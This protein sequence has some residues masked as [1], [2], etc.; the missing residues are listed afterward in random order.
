MR[1]PAGRATLLDDHPEVRPGGALV[2]SYWNLNRVAFGGGR[3]IEALLDLLGS[4]AVLVQPAPAHPTRCC[5][6]FRPDL[7]RRKLGVNWGLFNFFLPPAAATVR[8][9][10][11]EVQPAV[12]VLTSVWAW[13]PLRGLG[14]R[15]PTVLDAHDVLAAAIAERF[16]PRHPFTRLVG[17]WE[18]A[19]VRAVDHLIV[20]SD[21]DAAGMC[22]RYGVAK[23]RVSVVPNGT[24][25]DLDQRA[26]EAP[27]DAHVLRRLADAG[28]VLLFMGKLDY[29]PNREAL[30]FLAD[31]VLPALDAAAP[32]RWRLLV[33]GGPVPSGRWPAAVVFTGR[34]PEVAPYL[35][36]ADVCVAP[37]FSGS[38]T[39][40][41]I[42][43]AMAAGRPVVA[44]PKAAEGLTAENGRHLL[45]AEATDFAAAV[46]RL[47]E[48]AE[49]AA[50][51]GQSGRELVRAQY[52]WDA[53]RARWRSVLQRWMELPPDRMPLPR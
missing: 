22:A 26:R 3:R 51:I 17:A 27:L 9:T 6:V 10:I 23:D 49:L 42:L 16:G 34:V 29:Q 4:R 36:R 24:D 2:L 1:L 19:V 11:R 38:G 28:R 25:L 40:L 52:S 33:V 41:K 35:V 20:C 7:G 37:I 18:G 13:A 21:A 47:G 12:V 31:V 15:P 8:R 48:D 44:T 5:R 46:L 14:H 39:R 53:S 32:G 30:R 43:E 45:I 50:R